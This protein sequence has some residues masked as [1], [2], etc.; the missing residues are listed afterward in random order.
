MMKSLTLRHFADQPQ[1]YLVFG[2]LSLLSATCLLLAS[3]AHA[4][5]FFT[6]EEEVE[7]QESEDEQGFTILNAF[8]PGSS[9]TDGSTTGTDTQQ[10]NQPRVWQD[11]EDVSGTSIEKRYLD[12]D[13]VR[14]RRELRKPLPKRKPFGNR[15]DSIEESINGLQAP[16]TGFSQ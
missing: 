11:F 9:N 2:S 3:P 5:D 12:S 4:D 6:H 16:N 1:R 13:E 7:A 10:R 8:S 14:L 15:L